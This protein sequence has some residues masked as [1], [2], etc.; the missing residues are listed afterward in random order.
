MGI[1]KLRNYYILATGP[2]SLPATLLKDSSEEISAPLSF[3][4]NTSFLTGIFP[5]PEKITVVTPLYKSDDHTLPDNYRP[6]SVLNILSKVIKRIALHQ[7]SEYLETNNMPC[8]YQYIV[9][10]N[11]DQQTIQLC[12]SQITSEEIW[13]RVILQVQF[14]W[15]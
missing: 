6:I 7:L 1:E 8:L 9:S 5:S 11:S 2:D 15:I 3:L 12:I 4:I 13:T 14:I 10:K